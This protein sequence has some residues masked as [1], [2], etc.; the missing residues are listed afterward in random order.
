MKEITVT[1]LK[2]LKDDNADFQ[3]IDVREDHEVEICEIG[4]DHLRMGEV[5]DNLDKISKTKQV[6]IHCRSGARSG[7]ICKA[8]ENEGYDNVY[9]LVGGILAWA[10]EIDT[11][12]ERY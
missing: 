2:K 3:L 4:G 11:D 1:E 9:N 12:M 8:L 5:L 7:N 6:V 10:D